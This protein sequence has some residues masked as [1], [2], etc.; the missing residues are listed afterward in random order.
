MNVG[1]PLFIET[2]RYADGRIHL[3]GLH[4][5]RMATTV[6]E[7]F[8]TSAQK[9]EETM[10]C[11]PEEIAASGTVKCR[12]IYGRDIE[13]IQY[14][15]Y[16]PRTLRRLRMV[17]DD[18]IDYHLKY[19]DRTCLDRHSAES[20]ADEGVII[21]KNG[22]I[23][24]CTYAN[25]LFH[26]GEKTYTPSRPLLEGVMRRH[27]IDSGAAEAIMLRVE[28]IMPGNILG[29][30]HVT[31]VNALMPPGSVPAIPVERITGLS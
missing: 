5:M 12:V 25:L 26:A 3:L 19:L 2:I 20:M 1:S 17:S 11:P 21:V 14:E 7:M 18:G 9:M 4:N 8:G 13:S 6:K 16:V 15:P 29:I 30:T 22:L 24:D 28:D 31:P 27:L 23:T 10:F